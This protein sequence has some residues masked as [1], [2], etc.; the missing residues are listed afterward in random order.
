[1]RSLRFIALLL[2]LAVSAASADK[3]LKD[4]TG[5]KVESVA[6]K[7]P[8]ASKQVQQVAQDR[9]DDYSAPQ[10]PVVD[11]YGSPQAPVK[12]T[13]GSPAA[14]VETAAPVQ[15]DVGT[16]GYYY[17]YYPVA[18][19]HQQTYQSGG[20]SPSK[21]EGGLLGGNTGILL[22]VGLGVLVLIAVAAMFTQTSSKRSFVPDNILT[23]E[24]LFDVLE[25]IHR[26]SDY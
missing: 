14:P 2:G 18:N 17:Y 9:Q 21:T 3:P 11:T 4:A 25:G 10:A 26:W 5:V 12:D 22:L 15:G 7:T 23:N 19:S 20:S 1:M 16:Q 24:M 6:P 13:Y 8:V